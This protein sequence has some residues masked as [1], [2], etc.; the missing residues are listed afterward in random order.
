MKIIKQKIML[1]LIS[2]FMLALFAGFVNATPQGP[3]NIT[4][5]D[6][7]RNSVSTSP[8]TIQAEAGNVTALVI[9]STR[10]TQAW[11][12]YYGNITGTI[13]LDDASNNTLYDWSLPNPTGEIYASNGS[14]V[15]WANVYCMNVSGTR[16]IT[17][18]DGA[19]GGPG[20]IYNINGSQIELN[21]GINVTDRDGLNETFNDTFDSSF[22]VG[23]ITIDS[24]DGCSEAH[25]FVDENHNTAWDE[26]LLSDNESLIFTAVIRS[27]QDMYKTT[28]TETADFQLLVLENGHSGSD[29]STTSYYFY[30]ELT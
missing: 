22:A 7:G 9:T 25:P 28:G 5:S 2:L 16:N 15:T 14:S 27:N 3:D 26:V 4:V 19:G 6:S 29:T 30:V 12:G 24:N 8:I 11:Q 1:G 23:S 20:V 21:F 18:S 13:T 17:G 10:V